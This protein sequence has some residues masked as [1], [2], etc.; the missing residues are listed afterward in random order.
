[1]TDTCPVCKHEFTVRE[2]FGDNVV[3]PNPNCKAVLETAYE[4]YWDGVDESYGSHVVGVAACATKR[5]HHS[6]SVA[7]SYKPT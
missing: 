4:E 3:C 5:C 2:P 7:T 6:R 1:M